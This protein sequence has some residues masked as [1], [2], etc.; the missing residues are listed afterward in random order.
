MKKIISREKKGENVRYIVF[1]LVL[2]FSLIFSVVVLYAHRVSADDHGKSVDT[3]LQEIRA[4]QGLGPNGTIDPRKVSNREL[5]ELGDAVMSREFPDPEQ[6]EY[7]DD[8]MGGEGSRSLELMHRQMG[9]N[10][11][12][13]RPYD[14]NDVRREIGGSR[15]ERGHK[16]YE[17]HEGMMGG[18]MM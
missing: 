6:H 5:E 8:M 13:G 9:Y 3:I 10:Y 15:G 2:V 1:L 18:G 17:G 11:L 16:G 7:M 4:E 14:F 12:A